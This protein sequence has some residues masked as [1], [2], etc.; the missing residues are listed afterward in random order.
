MYFKRLEIHGFKSFADPVVIDFDSGVTCIVG[1]NGSGKSNISDA[2]RWVLGEQSPRQ[3]RGGIME[4]VIFN[5]TENRKAA[6]M[7]AVTLIIDNSSRI[8]DLDFAEVAVTRRLFRSG[9]S[10][11]AINNNVCRLKDIRELFM[12]TGIGVDGYSIIGQGKIQDIVSNKPESRRGIFEEAAGIVSYKSQKAETEKKLIETNRNLEKIDGIVDE[13]EGRVNTLKNDSE[14]AEQYLSLRKRYKELE[15]NIILKNIDNAADR[16]GKLLGEISDMKAKIDFTADNRKKTADDLLEQDRRA[17]K[18]ETM[19]DEASSQ[20]MPL[21]ESISNFKKESQFNDERMRIIKNEEVRVEKELDELKKK[22]DKI[23]NDLQSLKV[24]QTV[25]LTRTHEAENDLEEKK[26]VLKR[27]I[28]QTGNTIELIDEGNDRLYLLHSEAA[29]KKSEAQSIESY[30]TTLSKRL[31]ELKNDH[32]TMTTQKS[33]YSRLLR[34]IETKKM[35]ARSEKERIEKEIIETRKRRDDLNEQFVEGRDKVEKLRIEIKGME[36]R[37]RTIEEMEHNY[38]GYS[39]A[40]RFVLNSGLTGVEGVAGELLDVPVGMETAIETALGA[41]KQNIVVRNDDCATKAINALKHNKAG[42]LTFL[43]IDSIET[44]RASVNVDVEGDRDFLG[45]A[46]DIVHF[47]EAFR[48]VFRYLLG[49]AAIVTDLDAAIRLAKLD[50]E[51]LRFITLEGE[52]VN[53]NGAITGGQYK[54]KQTGILRRKNEIAQLANDIVLQKDKLDKEARNIADID[55]AVGKLEYQLTEL[56][57]DQRENA[58]KIKSLEIEEQSRKEMIDDAT[59]EIEKAGTEIDEIGR[60]MTDADRMISGLLEESKTAENQIIKVTHEI[61]EIIENGEEK[62]AAVEAAEKDVTESRLRVHEWSGKRDSI[63]ALIEKTKQELNGY[64]ALH[65]EKQNET[66]RLEREKS[67]LNVGT[68]FSSSTLDKL[69][70]DRK[71]LEDRIAQLSND[72]REA[73]DRMTALN[74]ELESYD[75]EISGYV[76]QKYSLEIQSAKNETQMDH[77]KSRLWDEFELS[78]AQAL[79][80]KWD[81]FVMGTSVKESRDLKNQIKSLGEVNIG[82]IREYKNISKRYKFLAEQ[83]SDIRSSAEELKLIIADMDKKITRRFRNNFEQ[84]EYNFE[85][86]FMELFGG[87]FAELRLEDD[88]RPLESGIEIIVQPPGKKLQNIN[89]LSGGE[90]TMTAIALMFALICVK[91]T[92]FCILDEVEAALDEDNIAR[93]SNYMKNFRQTQFALI[94]HQKATMEHADALYGVTMAE[95]GISKVISLKLDDPDADR[96]TE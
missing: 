68:N 89:L 34:E 36:T 41:G 25:I 47:N 86:V 70:Q 11:Y 15:V 1:P 7:A 73:A 90:K 17:K 2:I 92:P 80:L 71:S 37:S 29:S 60:Q 6:G 83:Q 14:K 9:D 28:D 54:K 31:R 19:Y 95:E 27:A 91:P 78:F 12:D 39:N 48:G 49:R 46:V 88:T 16:A 81:I 85:R 5:G 64:V 75:T 76:D 20:M 96:F 45:L 18:L 38:E 82:A 10:E 4:E 23:E 59:E 57:E 66:K 50:T 3:L 84:I 44:K 52:L 63:A 26:Q 13:L 67:H 77:L 22:I 43:P 74:A 40:V 58:L 93:F 65:E 32:E 51:G 35:N 42:R 56:L 8:L 72:K 87:G 30:K 55:R 79:E 53:S 61:D 24:E 69:E 62:R 21:I 94:T 33:R